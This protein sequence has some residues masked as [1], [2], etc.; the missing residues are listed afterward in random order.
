MLSSGCCESHIRQGL[1]WAWIPE[2]CQTVTRGTPS[3]LLPKAVCLFIVGKLL[4][5]SSGKEANSPQLF[6]W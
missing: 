4:T 3:S 6:V 2:Q 5:V 1:E